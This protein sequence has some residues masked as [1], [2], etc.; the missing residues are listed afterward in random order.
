[1][2]NI[3]E[4]R[5]TGLFCYIDCRVDSLLSNDF[6][7][8]NLW[9][10]PVYEYVIETV[11]SSY[12]FEHI[13]VVTDSI[14]IKKALIED[15]RIA[16]QSDLFLPQQDSI[17]CIISGRAVMIK[18]DTIKRARFMFH[19]GIMYSTARREEFNYLSPR[20]FRS[21]IK[22]HVNSPNNAFTFYQIK[23]GE[24]KE[25]PFTQFE[26]DINETVVINTVN[27]FELSVVLKKKEENKRFLSRAILEGIEKK[28][29]ILSSGIDMQSICLV[30]HSQIDYWDIDY[31]AGYRV[32]NCG[33]AGISSF[34]YEKYILS[35]GLLDC[36][37]EIFVIMH[38]TNDIVTEKTTE[39]IILSIQRSISYIRE[40]NKKALIYF[41]SCLH[42]NGRLDRNNREIDELN[43]EL[44]K[45]IGN[46]VKWVDT[47]FMDD[48]FG[49]LDA[50]NT[51]DGLHLSDYGY[52]IL[53]N[54]LEA[55]LIEDTKNEV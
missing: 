12:V 10:K 19:G 20:H 24:I 8:L 41:I 42:T 5:K 51:I 50:R 27:D 17:V 23:D 32:R 35:K 1:M 44:K 39:E 47:S 36:S 11:I 29:G 13:I 37:S 18:S 45:K 26:L 48:E 22:G 43:F 6:L 9:G 46:F 16:V 4:N 21:F 28:K 40:K 54:Q 53:Q 2:N 55:R 31:L 49:E 14:K 3:D 15:D 33:I 7:N 34:E 38:G 30:G 52:K 25:N